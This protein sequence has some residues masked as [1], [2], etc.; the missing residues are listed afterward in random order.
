MR[1]K[2]MAGRRR[3]AVLG[4]SE[5]NGTGWEIVKALVRQ[6]DFVTIGARRREGI[7]RLAG[8]VGG[9]AFP[10]DAVIEAQVERFMTE[11]AAEGPLD[12]AVLVAGAGVK[13][14]IDD[15]PPERLAHCLKLNFEAPL[16]F[17]RHAARKLKDHGSI[18]LISS[19]A[20]NNVW[21][22]YV[23]YGAAKSA[24]QMLVKYAAVEYGARG[25]RVNAV[26]PGPISTPAAQ[27]LVDHPKAGPIVAGEVPL[28]RVAGPAEVA[29]AVAWLC[30][31]PAWI[32]GETVHTDGGM[33]L[34]R[35]P[36][37]EDLQTA[38]AS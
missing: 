12:C 22:G 24:M 18:V 29:E 13:G 15:I 33:F 28:G 26:C 11:A 34:R 5:E 16:L 30:T 20:G 1:A 25:I 23:A 31:S 36:N 14:H 27:Y 35:P 37:V 3:A 2:D 17:I 6:G 8:Q 32:T 19:I 9:K 38:L 7:E 10:A 21:P 4:A